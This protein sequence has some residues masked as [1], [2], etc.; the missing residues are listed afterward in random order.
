MEKADDFYSSDEDD[1]QSSSTASEIGGPKFKVDDPCASPPDLWAL[2]PDLMPLACNTA[3]SCA[4]A[5][6][7]CGHYLLGL[8]F[9]IIKGWSHL[10]GHPT[11]THLRI[12]AEA[13][14]RQQV[15]IK[16]ALPAS[17][18]AGNAGALRAAA[19][20]LR[21]PT[22]A[23]SFLP[24]PG[25]GAEPLR[26]LRS[27]RSTDSLPGTQS[28]QVAVSR[29]HLLFC[30]CIAACLMPTLI[31]PCAPLLRGSAHSVAL[32]SD[33]TACEQLCLVPARPSTQC[34]VKCSKCFTR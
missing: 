25:A 21:L 29:V 31:S 20:Q 6:C 11:M 10:T 33:K 4:N 24:P 5:T 3:S 30:Q 16:D 13:V 32:T 23:S 12:S 2:V 34:F 27:H 15:V 1:T 26:S 14:M 7:K 19:Q 8:A 28:A 17:S 22:S 18:T 9:K